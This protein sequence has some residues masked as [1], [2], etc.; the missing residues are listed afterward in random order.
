M[1]H[2]HQVQII[3]M[4]SFKLNTLNV[5]KTRVEM[6]R[7]IGDNSTSILREYSQIAMCKLGFDVSEFR[8]AN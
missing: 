1:S 7:R 2:L 5:A 4:S 8:D 3:N 6:A